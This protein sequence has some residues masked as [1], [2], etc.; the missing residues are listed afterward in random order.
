M[1]QELWI[2]FT[3]HLQQK[4]SDKSSVHA[5]QIYV[6]SLFNFDIIHYDAVKFEKLRKKI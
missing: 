4:P 6:S 3:T 2:R 1:V 5:I